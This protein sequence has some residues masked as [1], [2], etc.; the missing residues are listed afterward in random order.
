MD[1]RDL[2]RA[3]DRLTAAL[4]RNTAATERLGGEFAALRA[5]APAPKPPAPPLAEALGEATG[6]AVV[7]GLKN[8]FGKKKGR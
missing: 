6:D 1:E 2:L 4:E 3:L 7:K 5:N 8:L